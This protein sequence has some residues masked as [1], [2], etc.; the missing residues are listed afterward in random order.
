MIGTGSD[1]EE[2]QFPGC[3]GYAGSSTYCVTCSSK[4]R[5][6]R[7]TLSQQTKRLLQRLRKHQNRA[8][9]L[10]P[11]TLR[12]DGDGAEVTEPGERGGSR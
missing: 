7:F 9:S 1:T 11:T 5:S 4:T 2:C 3:G 8:V 12:P 6:P 10:V